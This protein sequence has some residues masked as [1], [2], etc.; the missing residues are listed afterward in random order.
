MTLPQLD[1]LK[2]IEVTEE[3][4][5]VHQIKASAMFTR[6]DGLILLPKK[7]RNLQTVI[8]DLNLEA[9][10]IKD[11]YREF[12][13]VSD[14]VCTHTHLDHSAHVHIW[15]ELGAKISAP[16]QE[17]QNLLDNHT[18]LEKFGFLDCVSPQTGE[19]FT[20][21]MGYQGCKEVSPLNPGETL[22]FDDLEVETIHFPG[23]SFGHIGFFIPSN[24]ILHISC[25]GFDQIKP[26]V[27]G[28]GPWYGFRHCSIPQYFEDIAYAEKIFMERAKLLTSSHSYIV[29]NPDTTPFEYM[30]AKIEHNQTIVDQ[31]ILSLKPPPNTNIT[32]E[33]LLEMDLFF[34]KEKMRGFLKEIYTLWEYWIIEKH[35]AK[36]KYLK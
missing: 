14:Y 30:R 26:G 32:I 5:L 3:V 24:E 22:K 21:A 2:I 13:P 23:H 1:N 17:Y 34:P 31:A 20:S 15:E 6:C 18:F 8:L 29:K 9:K 33:E 36:S 4:L 25:L 35:L 19:Q 12:G 16:I 11:I 28:F 7:G 27:D 10:Y